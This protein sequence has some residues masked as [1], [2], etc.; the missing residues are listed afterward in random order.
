MMKTIDAK[1]MKYKDLNKLIDETMAGQAELLLDNVCGQRYIG[2]VLPQGAK[3]SIKGIPG[4]DMG[5]F[6]DGGE[7]EVFGNA[8]D[9]IGNTMNAGTII[10]HGDCGDIAG[11]AMRGGQIYIE[12][13]VGYRVG[14]HMKEYKD[15]KPVIV[16]GGKAGDYLGEYMAGGTII[17]LGQGIKNIDE[18]TGRYCATGMHGGKLFCCQKLPAYKLGKEASKVKL[19]EDDKVFLKKHL[20][21]YAQYFKKDLSTLNIDSFVKYAAVNKNPYKNLYCKV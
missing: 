8:Q 5:A 12:G 9:G 14:I 19:D 2:R 11:Y 4:N 16:I 20:D 21:A 7:L 10:V 17:L 6:M 13:N 3:I 18:L 1:G 15:M